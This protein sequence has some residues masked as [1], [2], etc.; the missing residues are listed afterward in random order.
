MSGTKYTQFEGHMAEFMWRA[1][2]KGNVYNS[3]FDLLRSI[4]PL[5]RDPEYHYST[6]LFDTLVDP[7]SSVE[8]IMVHPALTDAD[9]E[10][11][12][13]SVHS[14][15]DRA[16]SNQASS[17]DSGDYQFPPNLPVAES[18]DASDTAADLLIALS[19]SLSISDDDH[20]ATLTGA[21]GGASLPESPLP[22]LPIQGP[23][24]KPSWVTLRKKKSTPK[25]MNKKEKVC[26]PEFFEENSQQAPHGRQRRTKKTNPYAKTAFVWSSS[27]DDFK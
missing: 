4:Y 2:A 21:E 27:D 8:D 20:D 7:S 3:F 18:A 26:C 23:S 24:T 25:S 22:P 10:T 6:P 14:V 19:S 9:T 16:T 11:D 1:E 5:D 12:S 15:S 17:T 13:D